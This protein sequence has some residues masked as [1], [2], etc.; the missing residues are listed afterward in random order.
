MSQTLV[1]GC[2]NG[3]NVVIV[4]FACLAPFKT[5]FFSFIYYKIVKFKYLRE[6]WTLH[7]IKYA[8]FRSLSLFTLTLE[9]CVRAQLGARNLKIHFFFFL[10]AMPSSLDIL[11][12]QSYYLPTLWDCSTLSS[13][14]LF[15]KPVGWRGNKLYKE[16]GLVHYVSFVLSHPQDS[17]RARTPSSSLGRHSLENLTS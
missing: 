10:T 1:E 8:K 2:V 15:I 11:L 9:I 13:R 14:R 7:I 4:Y 6:K 16:K 12:K 17:L 3:W 5:S